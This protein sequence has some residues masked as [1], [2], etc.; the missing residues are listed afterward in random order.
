MK[1]RALAIALVCLTSTIWAAPA[2]SQALVEGLQ[3]AVT[4]SVWGSGMDGDVGLGNVSGQVGEGLSELEPNGVVRFE[5]KGPVFTL[6]VELLAGGN[7][8]DLENA[9]GSLDADIFTAE[10]LSGWQFS[11]TAELI[12]GARYYESESELDFA[13]VVVGGGASSFDADQSWVDPVVGIFYGGQVARYWT[14]HFRLDVAGFGLGSDLVV[15]S[16]FEFGYEFNDSV[17]LTL[18]YRAL[19]IDY[20]ANNYVYDILQQGPELGLRFA[21]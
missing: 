4:P 13:P 5:A 18:G 12:F 1:S 3:Y 16:R 10:L 6:R 8:H 7:D 11:E 15:N 20:D 9:D 19:D 17:A 2:S 14:Y 21:F